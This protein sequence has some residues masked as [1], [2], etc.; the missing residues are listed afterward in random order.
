MAEVSAASGAV[1]FGADHHVA[2]IFS[3][4]DGVGQCGEKARPSAAA[5]VLR[6]CIEQ[7]LS[8]GGTRECAV[9]FLVVQRTGTGSLCAVLAEYTIL[10]RREFRFPLVLS[11]LNRKSRILHAVSLTF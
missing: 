9:S 4:A 5:L 6:L 3:G 11:L 1:D 8:A 2:S 10:F 7:R